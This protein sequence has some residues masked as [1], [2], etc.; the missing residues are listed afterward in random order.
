MDSGSANSF[1]L[2][3]AL[4]HGRDI[5]RPRQDSSTYLSVIP[6]VLNDS[7]VLAQRLVRNSLKDVSKISTISSKLIR[8][9]QHVSRDKEV[10]ERKTTFPEASINR[11]RSTDLLNSEKISELQIPPSQLAPD[12]DPKQTKMLNYEEMKQIALSIAHEPQIRLLP[13]ADK[14]IS[15]AQKFVEAMD[16]AK[17]GDCR[18]EH[19]HLGILAIPFLLKDTLTD[20]GCKW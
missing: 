20:E 1:F 10:S 4:N 16:H 7:S 18:F 5:P 11:Q 2:W 9:R 3:I 19:A 13:G 6:I 15:G 8:K 12:G 17:R 14:K